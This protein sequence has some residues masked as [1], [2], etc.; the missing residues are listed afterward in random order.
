M[1]NNFIYNQLEKIQ[2]KGILVGLWLLTT[3]IFT[4]LLQQLL[5]WGI[6]LL[7]GFIQQSQEIGRTLQFTGLLPK[8]LPMVSFQVTLFLFVILFLVLLFV[9]YRYY[10]K[11]EFAYGSLLSGEKATGRFTTDEEIK[12][13]YKAIPKY[14]KLEKQET[15]TF[16]VEER[17]QQEEKRKQTNQ[18]YEGLAGVLV[19][20]I[21]D[22]LFIDTDNAH[23]LILG[24]TRSGK[25]QSK[26]LSDIEITSRSEEK[27]HMIISSGKYELLQGTQTML[28][29]RGYQIEVLNLIDMERSIQFNPLTM[30][31]KRYLE[32]DYDEAIE[33]CKTFSYPLYHN[34]NTK[35]PV[36]EETAM[37]LV[38]ALI[39][40]L[41]HEFVGEGDNLKPEGIHQVNMYN[42]AQML[43]SLGETEN[44]S[45]YLLDTYFNSLDINNPARVEYSTVSMSTSQMRSSIFTS[46]QAKIRNFT[47]R[48][49]AKLMDT[50]SFS[51]E[52]FVTPDE[53]GELK[54]IALFLVLPDYVETNY[55]IATTFLQQCYYHLS[56]YASLHDDRLPKRIMHH[57][58]E[59]GNMPAFTG[60]GSM[61]TVGA[62]RG[63]LYHLYLQDLVQFDIKYGADISRLLR[64]QTMNRFFILSG[65]SE[66]RREFSEWLG[67][68]EFIQK[69]RSGKFKELDKSVTENVETR[70]L[71]TPDE[72]GRL[73][74]GE[75]VVERSTKRRDLKGRKIRPYPIFNT[76]EDREFEYAYE[77]LGDLVKK[78]PIA[79]LDLPTITEE[80]LHANEKAFIRKIETLKRNF[81]QQEEAKKKKESSTE[82]TVENAP[83]NGTI[84]Y[85]TY[86]QELAA[87][88]ISGFDPHNLE[89]QKA[90]FKK[91]LAESSNGFLI[92][93]LN[94]IDTIEELLDFKERHSD[95]F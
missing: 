36:W 63:L 81:M 89:E 8:Q 34:E 83:L 20:R 78:V 71:L 24:R 57:L 47:A 45:S 18:A 95:I 31:A 60:I 82:K 49:V 1:I 6:R 30:I 53:N 67:S 3:T 43:N 17:K 84:V 14:Q 94:G 48:R 46:A 90:Y 85:P 9:V 65:D 79:E 29:E 70:P 64:S 25:T 91:V 7:L 74:E 12:K 56:Q 19:A 32:G 62:G 33:L 77:Y 35:E 87:S 80:S 68:R 50:T 15:D 10:R 40:A 41:C 44:G 42:V 54:P 88:S 86:N 37:A 93:E 23:S 27:P 59:F 13:Q 11:L 2:S 28:K 72:L 51:F 38:N 26:V 4:V 52:R 5:V 73:R 92:G 66:T 22:T 76:G 39:L 69:S 58:D 16:N 21:K 61:L 75:I 55:I